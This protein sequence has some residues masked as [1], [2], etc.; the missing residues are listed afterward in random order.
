MRLLFLTPYLPGPPLFGGARRIHGLMSQLAGSH[1]VS[2]LSLVLASEDQGAGIAKA[3][4][5]CQRVEVVADDWHRMQ[6]KAKRVFQLASLLS[7]WSWEKVLYLRPALQRTLDAHLRRYEYDAVVCEFAFMAYFRFPRGSRRPRLVLDEHNVEYDLLRRTAEATAIGRRVFQ[8]LNWRKLK[9]EEVALWRRFDACALTSARDRTLVQQEAPDLPTAVV[10]NGVD[11]EEFAPAADTAVARNTL[12]FF[13]A[14]NY[15]PNTDGALYFAREMLPSLLAHDP[16]IQLRIVGPVGDGPVT[17]LRSQSVQVLGFVDD[18]KAEI[19]KAA[20]VVV[21][22]RIGGGTRLKILEAM[23]MGKAVVST[24]LGAE[25]L[26]VEHDKDILIA[27]TP[28]D[29]VRQVQT[30][31]ASPELR[32]RLGREAR[33]TAEERYSWPSCAAKMEALLLSVISEKSTP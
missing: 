27:D 9:R 2:L 10:P 8:E 11:I 4:T 24:S 22:L 30:A 32:R 28:A 6:G 12:L 29:F 7:P 33:K 14:I 19:A 26:D 23:A 16:S 21:P 13:G 17:D 15:Y 20:V 31:L 5:Y 18:V 25:G 3:Q 1:E